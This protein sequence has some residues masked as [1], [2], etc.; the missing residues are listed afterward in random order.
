MLPEISLTILKA[1]LKESMKSKKIILEW[2]FVL[3]TVKQKVKKA[4]LLDGYDL[5][6]M[7]SL[8]KDYHL[9]RV[10]IFF[11]FYYLIPLIPATAYL[12]TWVIYCLCGLHFEAMHNLWVIWVWYKWITGLGPF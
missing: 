8:L 11:C 7:C 1:L 12:L 4:Q 10:R 2:S 6:L 5:Y 9:V 3:E